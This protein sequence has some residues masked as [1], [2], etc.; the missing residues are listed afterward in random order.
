MNGQDSVAED[1]AILAALLHHFAANS[2][3]RAGA[4]THQGES[5]W[6]RDARLEQVDRRGMARDEK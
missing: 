3:A 2:A 1:A 5:L 6:K 4:P